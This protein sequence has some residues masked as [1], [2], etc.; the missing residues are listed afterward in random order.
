MTGRGTGLAIAMDIDQPKSGEQPR[1]GTSERA[2]PVSP[3]PLL[4]EARRRQ[5][6]KNWA[7]MIVLASL[8][9]LFYLIT[10]VRMG[11]HG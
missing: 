3:A 8:A 11:G 4:A 9:V 6:R 5:R 2:M 1:T 10:I 7:L